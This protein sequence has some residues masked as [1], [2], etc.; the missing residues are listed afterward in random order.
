M[1]EPP[2][3]IGLGQVVGFILRRDAAG[4]K[5][6]PSAAIGF[7]FG[8]LMLN[9]ESLSRSLRFLQLSSLRL[10]LVVPDSFKKKVMN[11]S[12]VLNSG[13][14]KKQK[15]PRAVHALSYQLCT[16]EFNTVLFR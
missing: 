5:T 11:E 8:V 14:N 16:H 6:Q 2:S 3:L 9:T 1:S 12:V 13:L 4:Y 10:F 7:V 15:K